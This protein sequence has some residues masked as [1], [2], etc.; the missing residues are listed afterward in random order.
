MLKKIIYLMATFLLSVS[1]FAA[2]NANSCK[3]TIERIYA[4]QSG[5]VYIEPSDSMASLNCRPKSDV[6]LSLKKTHLLFDEI[7]KFYM[8]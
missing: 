6:F 8:P 7:Y 3:T 1:T 5:V 4:S 2:C